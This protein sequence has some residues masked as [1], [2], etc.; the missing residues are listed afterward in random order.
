MNAT[1]V[2]F[3][4][5]KER[6]QGHLFMKLVRHIDQCFECNAFFQSQK[7]KLNYDIVKNM[8]CV[9]SH[10][11]LYDVGYNIYQLLSKSRF[12]SDIGRRIFSYED[13]GLNMAT[14]YDLFCVKWGNFVREN[15][16]GNYYKYFIPCYMRE[17]DDYKSRNGYHNI[18]FS[19]R[20][21]AW[22]ES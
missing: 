14:A 17:F 22:E 1:Q 3:L 21:K 19:L 6:K 10:S 9:S 15:I 8:L 7:K 16:N 20:P 18:D 13:F 11:R 5:L 2:L 4:F 12:D